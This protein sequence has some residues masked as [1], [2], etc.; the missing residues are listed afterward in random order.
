MC[1]LRR[2][3][4]PQLVKIG[5][6]H[7]FRAERA[8]IAHRADKSDSFCKASG[9]GHVLSAG[10]SGCQGEMGEQTLLIRAEKSRKD[11]G[12]A[13][14]SLGPLEGR[15]VDVEDTPLVCALLA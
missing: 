3:I 1:A 10:C 9:A 6:F 8:K 13:T 5:S 14:N 11:A 15:D 2:H 12:P 4:H 7:R